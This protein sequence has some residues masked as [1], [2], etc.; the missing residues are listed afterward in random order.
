M[1]RSKT[2]FLICALFIVAC[3]KEYTTGPEVFQNECV[4]CHKLNGEG[5]KKGPELTDIFAKKDE[6]YIRQYIMDPRSIKPDGTMPPAKLSDRELNLIVEYLKQQT[7][8]RS[9]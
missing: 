9:K 8:R 5:G 7:L 3:R 6:D 4:K 1:K 2:F